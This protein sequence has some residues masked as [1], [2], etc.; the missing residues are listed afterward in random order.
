MFLFVFKKFIWALSLV[1]HTIQLVTKCL[2]M[3][4]KCDQASDLWQELELASEFESNLQDTVIETEGA[5][6]ISMLLKLNWFHLNYLITL[7]LLM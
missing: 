6:L 3:A 4:L 5:L 2:G 1:T 7:V